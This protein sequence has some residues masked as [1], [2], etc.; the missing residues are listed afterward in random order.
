MQYSEIYREGTSTKAFL[1][2]AAAGLGVFIFVTIRSY[3]W[4][5]AEQASPHPRTGFPPSF[6]LFM[7]LMYAIPTIVGVFVASAISFGIVEFIRRKRGSSKT[8][9]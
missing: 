4:L 3:L 1:L 9:V 8:Q 5:S 6:A 7:G 2:A